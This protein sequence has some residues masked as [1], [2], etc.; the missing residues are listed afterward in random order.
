M[1]KWAKWKVYAKTRKQYY[2]GLKEIGYNGFDGLELVQ[3]I[4]LTGLIYF[5]VSY[6]G[7]LLN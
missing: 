6:N 2:N 5:R 7:G 3:V 1:W 4:P